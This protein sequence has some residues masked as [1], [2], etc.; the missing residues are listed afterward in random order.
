MLINHNPTNG[1]KLSVLT[2]RDK[3]MLE[4]YIQHKSKAMTAEITA[5][6]ILFIHLSYFSSSFISHFYSFLSV[7]AQIVFTRPTFNKSFVRMPSYKKRTSDAFQSIHL[8]GFLI[9]TFIHLIFWPRNRN[10]ISDTKEIQ[11]FEFWNDE[12]IS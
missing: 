8:K 10:K 2:V 12:K 3:I 7:I 9:K 1:N 4:L 6:I 5:D 11:A